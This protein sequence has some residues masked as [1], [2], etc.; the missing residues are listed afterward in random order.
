MTRIGRRSIDAC[1][2]RGCGGFL[3][4]VGTEVH[5]GEVAHCAA[6]HRA[7][8]FIVFDDGSAYVEIERKQPR[9]R[10]KGAGRGVR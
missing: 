8:M 3:R 5:D 1:V 9:K 10:A 7:H 2:A 6:C 4:G